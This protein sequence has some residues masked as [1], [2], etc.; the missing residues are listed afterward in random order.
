MCELS[1]FMASLIILVVLISVGIV[2]IPKLFKN[3]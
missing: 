2:Y 3:L 1:G